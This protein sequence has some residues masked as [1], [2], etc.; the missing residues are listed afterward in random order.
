[1]SFVAQLQLSLCEDCSKAG[2]CI[3]FLHINNLFL[4]L[5]LILV[6]RRCLMKQNLQQP[7]C[8]ECGESITNLL[9]PEC[10]MAEAR[11]CLA[12]RYMSGKLK[13]WEID[14]INERLAKVLKAS[15]SEEGI[16]CIKCGSSISVCPHCTARYLKDILPR[17]LADFLFSSSFSFLSY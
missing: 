17:N 4:S 1:M 8:M 2:S 7:L 12:D 11:A 14:E 13:E 10:I 5:S 3:V 9:C 15:Y 6:S 16:G